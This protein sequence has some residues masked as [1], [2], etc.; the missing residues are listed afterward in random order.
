MT[1]TLRFLA[2]G[3]TY[4]SLGFQLRISYSAISYIVMSV[5]EALVANIGKEYL[6]TPTKEWEFISQDFK[7]KW[8]F[9]NA[10]GAIDGKHIVIIPPPN[11]GSNYYNYKHTNSIVLLAIDG[12][13]YPNCP[14]YPNYP[15]CPNYECLFADVG[16]NGRMNDSGIWNKSSLRHAIESGEMEF[17]EPKALSYRSE[18]LPF[19]IVGDDAFAL[20]N[21]MMKPFPQRNL[22]TEKRIYNY[23]HSRARR[24]SEN[25]FGILANRWRIFHTTMH[26]SPER[27][28][29]VT[30]SD[31]V[32]HNFLLKSLS[33]SVYCAPGLLDQEDTQ[34]NV[35]AGSWRTENAAEGFRELSPQ[36]HGNNISKTAKN[37]REVFMDYFMNEGA[38]PWQWDKC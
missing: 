7:E 11:S 21:Y 33:K 32:L 34:G 5:C 27:A 22:T 31:L 26:L 6:K 37:I 16:S 29:S 9:P 23:R 38:L 18:K 2:T 30:L 25:M 14:N 3:E 19:V 20:K 24:I 8:Q 35:V 10:L 12:P 1:L 36:S 15:N 17:P 4:R 28:T 13:N